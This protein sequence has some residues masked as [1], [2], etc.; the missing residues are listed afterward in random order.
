MRQKRSDDVANRA[1]QVFVAL[2]VRD[3]NPNCLVDVARD[4]HDARFEAPVDAPGEV[5]GVADSEQD[6]VAN[7]R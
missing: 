3:V 5:R 7:G 1:E 6:P 4:A 2:G